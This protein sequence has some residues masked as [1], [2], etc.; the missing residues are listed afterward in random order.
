MKIPIVFLVEGTGTST[1]AVIVTVA[2]RDDDGSA[3]GSSVR[4]KN[5]LSLF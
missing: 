5:K 4:S 1:S 2:H 3:N